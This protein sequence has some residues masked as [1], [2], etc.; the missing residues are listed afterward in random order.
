MTELSN[1]L[2]W[3]VPLS[4]LPLL[5]G[6]MESLDG[7]R[8]DKLFLG[9]A[10]MVAKRDIAVAWKDPASP[11]ITKWR[12]EVDWCAMQEKPVYEARGCPAKY[13][14]IWDKWLGLVK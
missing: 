11:P 4:P 13:G 6:V 8:T 12:K 9:V 10:T 2:G 3:T 1:I 14:R 7:S 5:L